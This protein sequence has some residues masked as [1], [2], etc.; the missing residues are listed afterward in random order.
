MDESMAQVGCIPPYIPLNI[1]EDYP[2]CLNETSGLVAYRIYEKMTN[3]ERFDKKSK[4][5]YQVFTSLHFKKCI[6]SIQ[7]K[8][9][10]TIMEFKQQL[11]KSDYKGTMDNPKL[12]IKLPS[13]IE[14]CSL[15]KSKKK[16]IKKLYFE[17]SEQFYTFHLVSV[18][19]MCGGYVGLF[20]GASFFSII[21]DTIQIGMKCFKKTA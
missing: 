3:E 1:S 8:R 5:W 19:A 7:I 10:C 17:V 15:Y 12:E 4:V 13:L 11:Q 18:I 21:D 14:V 16:T 2:V 20:L 6:F 9:P